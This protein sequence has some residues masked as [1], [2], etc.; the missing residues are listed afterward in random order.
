MKLGPFTLPET[1]AE[2]IL[3]SYASVIAQGKPSLRY[4]PSDEMLVSCAYRSHDGLKCAAGFFIEDANYYAIFEGKDVASVIR[5]SASME[6]QRQHLAGQMRN[7]LL[8]CQASHDHAASES[9]TDHALFLNKYKA[10]MRKVAAKHK[11]KLPK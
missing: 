11:V 3:Q 5:T 6:D 4:T 7:V 10:N 1:I 9:P 8:E 2:V